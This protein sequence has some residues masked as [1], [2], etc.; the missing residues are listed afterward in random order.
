MRIESEEHKTAFEIP[1]EPTVRQQLRYDAAWE[2]SD[3][4]GTFEKLWI[5]LSAIV[6]DWQSEIVPECRPSIL[7][8]L[9]SPEAAACIRW[10]GLETFAHMRQIE[11]VPK[12]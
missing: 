10:A 5:G 7:D 8:E 1:D 11:D 3:L 2:L 4:A 9:K 6:I 12:N